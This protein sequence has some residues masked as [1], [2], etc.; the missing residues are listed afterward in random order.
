MF[1]TRLRRGLP[2]IRD[3]FCNRKISETKAELV[4]NN[5][6]VV[7]QN[8]NNMKTNIETNTNMNTDITTGTSNAARPAFALKVIVAILSLTALCLSYRAANEAVALYGVLEQVQAALAN[9]Q[10]IKSQ[11]SAG[12]QIYE[13][14]PSLAGL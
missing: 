6:T 7:K 3:R 5:H 11:A 1:H 10:N 13:T 14:K 9:E 12:W 4:S 8:K 2:S